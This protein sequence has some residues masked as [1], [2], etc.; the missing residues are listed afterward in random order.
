MKK[1]DKI[2]GSSGV[3]LPSELFITPPSR[4]D[5]YEDIEN[6]YSNSIYKM[7]K[8]SLRFIIGNWGTGKSAIV[9]NFLPKLIDSDKI[10]YYS[11]QINEIFIE[12]QNDYYGTNKI[13]GI[14][15]I[16]LIFE[17]FRKNLKYKDNPLIQKYN[18]LGNLQ[19]FLNYIQTIDK[20][21][22]IIIDEFE[23]IITITK[24]SRFKSDF[25]IGLKY[26]LNQ[27]SILEKFNG[28]FHFVI[29]CTP[30][31]Y[32]EIERL[33]ELKEIYGGIDRRIIKTIIKPVRKYES[34]QFVLKLY[35]FSFNSTIPENYF[36]SIEG[37][38]LAI[39]RAGLF[40]FGKI[41]SMVSKLQNIYD[42]K[43]LNVQD[44]L[45]FFN[46]YKPDIDNSSV[47]KDTL[48]NQIKVDF[49]DI[50]SSNLLDYLIIDQNPIQISDLSQKIFIPEEDIR[51]KI[52]KINSILKQRNISEP[53]I[54]ANR[55][56]KG[57]F[58]IVVYNFFEKNGKIDK[59]D[60]DL[61]IFK[62]KSFEFEKS[63]FE[64][65]FQKYTYSN[66]EFQVD[67]IF[68]K[69][70][71]DFR[72]LFS[73][74][75]HDVCDII[76]E[77]IISSL[78]IDEKEDCILINPEFLN[79][80]YP[81]NFPIELDFFDDREEVFKIWR[82]IS[83][84]FEDF[85]NNFFELGLLEILKY[86]NNFTIL[87]KN[88]KEFLENIFEFE[89]E[90]NIKI[91]FSV[92]N[93]YSSLINNDFKAIYEN[94]QNLYNEFNPIKIQILFI[95]EEIDEFLKKEPYYVS[96]NKF[97]VENPTKIIIKKLSL[98]LIKKIIFI[99]I[100]YK[101]STI[102]FD[103][104]KMALLLEDTLK[105]TEIENDIL[106][107]YKEL[108]DQG[109]FFDIFED[110]TNVSIFKDFLKQIFTLYDNDKFN[111]NLFENYETLTKLKL[112][113]VK[114]KK[115]TSYDFSKKMFYEN[116]DLALKNNFL[117][118]NEDDLL[119]Y[120]FNSN[121]IQLQ[122]LFEKYLNGKPVT[123]AQIK[124]FIFYKPNVDDYLECYLMILE[125]FNI[126][127]SENSKK[128]KKFKYIKDQT[129]FKEIVRSNYNE[130]RKNL[131]KFNNKKYH[132]FNIKKKGNNLIYSKKFRDIAKKYSISI[133]NSEKL[134]K[135]PFLYQLN[136]ISMYFN[137]EICSFF[138][139]YEKIFQKIENFQSEVEIFINDITHSYELF[140]NSFPNIRDLDNLEEYKK[141]KSI[142]E[143]FHKFKSDIST[144]T[145]DED[146][147]EFA[148]QI[149]SS[150]D[151]VGQNMFDYSRIIDSKKNKFSIPYIGNIFLTYYYAR[152]TSWFHKFK[153]ETESIFEKSKK[154]L[155]KIEK[156][157]NIIM[158]VLKSDKIVNQD[159]II[160][161]KYEDIKKNNAKVVETFPKSKI[162]KLNSI[163]K[164]SDVIELYIGSLDIANIDLKKTRNEYEDLYNLEEK[165]RDEI[166][167]FQII[168]SINEIVLLEKNKFKLFLTELEALK[169][170]YNDFLE[171]DYKDTE[172]ESKLKK[173]RKNKPLNI[174]K[175]IE[176]F[177]EEMNSFI[178]DFNRTLEDL[179]LNNFDK[180]VIKKN[181]INIQ[182]LAH[183]LKNLS[184]K[185]L[186]T[187]ESSIRE[188]L[189]K[190]ISFTKQNE[191]KIFS[192]EEIIKK[193][194]NESSF[195][196]KFDS[197]E[198]LI[199][200]LKSKR[201]LVTLNQNEYRKLLEKNRLIKYSL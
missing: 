198:E 167:H 154:S 18:C 11:T 201:V 127:E 139:K 90:D 2:I 177:S 113:G 88:E 52:K 94:L 105:I 184:I 92:F 126:I 25:I 133:E 169:K 19:D 197:V 185:N 124:K 132:I 38:L 97:C 121:L 93:S 41:Q 33:P 75:E 103:I 71:H 3:N 172:L 155:K 84:N 135:I 49:A 65:I 37:Q 128:T 166:A 123:V 31:A 138:L 96:C 78:I 115:I 45:L 104:E 141:T 80:I 109:Y 74:F 188:N 102:T 159:F 143:N 42:G 140:K 4:E 111:Q 83:Y 157:Q 56:I 176:T 183:S 23:E 150:Q 91:S 72:K 28:I 147:I 182:K 51:R 101:N 136:E 86:L 6:F 173:I 165:L 122:D 95:T 62:Y 27:R 191:L 79:L 70:S 44:L 64:D 160:F 187:K 171:L 26:I 89:N 60:G 22:L 162:N 43:K 77:N 158:T 66:L 67:Y 53:L 58:P 21:I 100:I 48:L 55:I 54:M 175:L 63:V 15:F 170:Y 57:N 190:A 108:Q 163:K 125:I 61:I 186:K 153:K 98:Y 119:I 34:I 161:K 36:E 196:E 99:G 195:D 39:S 200:Y 30:S 24:N 120:K 87:K 9:D 35:S 174:E 137:E 179:K 129:D 10:F 130:F 116:L 68:P 152:L 199:L 156:T 106:Q 32:Y 107:K 180:S 117:K 146:L 151:D 69:T 131:D 82:N 178:K 189:E 145:S 168:E 50:V 46:K 16:R 134:Y 164:I 193:F 148:D 194:I 110:V 1:F 192:K 142:L 59:S 20:K 114:S 149:K 47:L 5:I 13:S 73:M 76:Y 81:T 29:C 112:Y 14:E 7:D 85:F 118:K 12:S 40:N 181:E 144:I 8:P 17:T